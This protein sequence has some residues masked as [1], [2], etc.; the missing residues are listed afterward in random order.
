LQAG[1][2]GEAI[3]TDARLAEMHVLAGE[4]EDAL[5]LVDEVLVRAER[6]GATLLVS[7]LLRVR[8]WALVQLGDAARAREPLDRSLTLARKRHDLYESALALE[9]L[10]RLEE[11]TTGDANG[12]DAE[13]RALFA[14][15][16]VV[17]SPRVPA[18]ARPSNDD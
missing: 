7:R 1:Q 4:P 5:L 12:L 3:A 2:Q 17:G 6:L 11:L 15:L 8:G 9:A 18:A 10:A 14:Q 13:A 16:G